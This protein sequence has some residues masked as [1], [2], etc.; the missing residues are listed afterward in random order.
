VEVPK[1]R[2]SAKAESK[3][4][5]QAKMKGSKTLETGE[6]L[7]WGMRNGRFILSCEVPSSVD[8]TGHAWLFPIAIM[9]ANL[10]STSPTGEA[11]FSL[12]NPKQIVWGLAP[13]KERK[14]MDDAPLAL[15]ETLPWS[16]FFCRS[17]ERRM[18]GL[19]WTLRREKDKSIRSS[20]N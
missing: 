15:W 14:E 17:R 16:P 11:V 4:E 7:G 12:S 13:M 18:L 20:F 3:S 1:E 6:T 9:T 10:W 5:A 8:G 2:G 19:T